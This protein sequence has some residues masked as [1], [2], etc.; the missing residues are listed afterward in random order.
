MSYNPAMYTGRL[1]ALDQSEMTDNYSLILLGLIG[2]WV[3]GR[4]SRQSNFTTFNLVEAE[5]EAGH[6]S[7]TQ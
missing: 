1:F 6:S 2:G 3:G 7:L 5:A 4:S